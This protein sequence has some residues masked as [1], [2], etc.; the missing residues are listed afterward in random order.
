MSEA[1][2]TTIRGIPAD[3]YKKLRI[4]A[5]TKEISINQAMIEAIER[6]VESEPAA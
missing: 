5:A 4:I 3:T 1:K 2:T 6:Y